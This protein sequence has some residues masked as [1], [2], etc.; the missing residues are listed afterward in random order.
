MNEII[1]AINKTALRSKKRKENQG[2]FRATENEIADERQET[3]TFN[4]NDTTTLFPAISAQSSNTGFR[5]VDVICFT[6]SSARANIPIC[7]IYHAIKRFQYVLW[8][9][10]KF[11]DHITPPSPL[12]FFD[13]WIH[14]LSSSSSDDGDDALPPTLP[15]SSLV[16]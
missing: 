4:A 2:L 12:T 6:C 14:F 9:F 10:A 3:N 16:T 15:S 5:E 7:K 1:S 11:N 13:S 8:R